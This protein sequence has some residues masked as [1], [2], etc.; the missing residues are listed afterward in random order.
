[1]LGAGAAYA[2]AFPAAVQQ[3]LACGVAIVV[4]ASNTTGTLYAV[5]IYITPCAVPGVVSLNNY[6]TA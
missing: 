1:M 6:R 4:A 5:L 3:L 2:Y